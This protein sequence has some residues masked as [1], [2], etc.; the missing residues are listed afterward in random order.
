MDQ[1][2][3]ESADQS[4]DIDTK[5]Q[6]NLLI[7]GKDLGN[8]RDY[9]KIGNS[10]GSTEMTSA[11]INNSSFLMMPN[12]NQSLLTVKDSPASSGVSQQVAKT[13]NKNNA[14][15]PYNLED[16]LMGEVQDQ[17]PADEEQEDGVLRLVD[18]KPNYN[19]AQQWSKIPP[20]SL[21]N[22]SHSLDHDTAAEAQQNS[23]EEY[24]TPGLQGI[25]KR[26][27]ATL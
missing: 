5:S 12:Q 9:L 13:K 10:K 26:S 3:I 24:G 19:S 20:P 8:T 22:V 21:K 18:Q 16:V 15:A 27:T 2:R 14:V 1:V 11:N 7:H 6:S 23:I 17:G 25:N 4:A